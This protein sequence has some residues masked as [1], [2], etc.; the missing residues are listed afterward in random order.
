VR[1]SATV[2]RGT[3][4]SVR[5][6]DSFLYNLGGDRVVAAMGLEGVIVR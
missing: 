3:V 5:N 6:Q 1:E 2:T 4:V